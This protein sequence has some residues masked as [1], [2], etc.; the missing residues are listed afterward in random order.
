[1]SARK[2][3]LGKLTSVAQQHAKKILDRSAR[4]RE[5]RA[6]RMAKRLLKRKMEEEE[7]KENEDDDDEEEEGGKAKKKRESMKRVRGG[8]ERT[9]DQGEKRDKEAKSRSVSAKNKSSLLSRNRSQ[10]MR[11][12]RAQT[13]YQSRKSHDSGSQSH[14]VR[15]AKKVRDK[16]QGLKDGGKGNERSKEEKVTEKKSAQVVSKPRRPYKVRPIERVRTRGYNL[17]LASKHALRRAKRDSGALLRNK[18]DLE[19]DGTKEKEGVQVGQAE[20]QYTVE[21]METGRELSAKRLIDKRNIYTV[22]SGEKRRYPLTAEEDNST[23]KKKSG[24]IASDTESVPSRRSS[25][26]SFTSKPSP[27]RLARRSKKAIIF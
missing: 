21:D 11:N 7:E 4:Q 13:L 17:L 27:A 23:S 25:R 14:S 24:S 15:G 3:L 6:E 20:M 10:E 9:R 18:R 22:G 8:D 5:G 1:M 2:S 19:N 12:S 16:R 26:E